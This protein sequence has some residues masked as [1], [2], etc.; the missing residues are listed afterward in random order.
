[1]IALA[2]SPGASAAGASLR[3]AFVAAGAALC[4]LASPARAQ[5]SGSVDVESDYRYRGYSLS[6]AQPSAT[7]RVGYDDESGAY[8]N[9]SAT[10][11]I[12]DNLRFVGVQGG[13]GYARRVGRKLTVDGGVL[14]TQYRATYSGGRLREYTEIYGGFSLD[15]VSV[16]LSWSPDYRPGHDAVYGEIEASFVPARSWRIDL[17][18]G[19][20]DEFGGGSVTKMRYDWRIG[21]ARRLGVFE[22]H[23]ALSGGGPGRDYY[24]G[25]L[26]NRTALTLGASWSF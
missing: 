4:L 5:L 20:L 21:A 18:L 9:L 15:P 17:H 12:D 25:R 10:L 8:A 23:A 24:A 19:A 6:A 1:M 16:R 26:H 2:R 13:V 11:A 22:L 7:V 3:P 14:R